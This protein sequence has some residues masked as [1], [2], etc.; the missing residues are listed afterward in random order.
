MTAVV[1]RDNDAMRQGQREELEE[2]KK[3]REAVER[4]GL[5]NLEEGGGGDI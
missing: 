4:N 3:K 1:Y 5:Q 2:R